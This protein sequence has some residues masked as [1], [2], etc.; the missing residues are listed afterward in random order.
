MKNNLSQDQELEIQ[1]LRK[2]VQNIRDEM[3]MDENPDIERYMDKLT[4]LVG[5]KSTTK[6]GKLVDELREAAEMEF[7][8]IHQ[9][10]I[11][12]MVRTIAKALIFLVQKEGR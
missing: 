4:E 8:S 10:K 6:K 3:G 2:G 5:G 12:G 9:V 11:G 1:R 7:Y